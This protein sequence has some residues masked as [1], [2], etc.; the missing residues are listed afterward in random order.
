MN[1]KVLIIGAQGYLGSK[2]VNYLS[3]KKNIKCTAYDTGFFK[4]SIIQ[5]DNLFYTKKIDA[6]HIQENDIL[7]FDVVIL[8]SAISNDPFGHLDPKNIYN[9]TRDYALKIANFCKKNKIKFIFPSSCSVYG[10]SNLTEMLSEQSVVNP[11]TFYSKNKLEIEKGLDEMSGNGFSPIALRLATVYGMSPRIRFDVVI[12]MLV[13]MAK[14]TNKI[15]LN[16]NGLAWRPNLYIDDACEAFYQSIITV[17]DNNI[18]NIINIGRDEDNLKIID[19]ANLIK[20]EVPESE[21]IFLDATK[22]NSNI[23]FKDKKIQDGV[24]TR[25]YRVS[26]QKAKEVFC[27]PPCKWN[28]RDGIR[29]LLK[30]F[31]D[32]NLSFE[33]VNNSDF[34]RLQHLDLLLT[35]NFI[36]KNLFWVKDY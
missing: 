32:I 5:K 2:L 33:D 8:L 34:Y 11:Q 10:A 16:S 22:D 6:R 13:A 20:N 18:L 24:D 12:N 19:I 36:N 27:T 9:P 25:T 14:T 35:N 29:Q 17:F 21:I 15:K 7:G 31:S 28:I 26:F 30:D 1:Y 23:L 3:L 4:K